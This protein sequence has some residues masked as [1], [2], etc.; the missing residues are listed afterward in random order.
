MKKFNNLQKTQEVN[1]KIS[2]IKLTEY[3]A[4]E[5]EILKEYLTEVLELKN[6]IN[7]MKN[8]LE[9]EQ[10]IWKR[11]LVSSGIGI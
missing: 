8:A 9:I 10:I 3:F 7:E 5:N 2:E 1:T 11:E 6:S 4:E